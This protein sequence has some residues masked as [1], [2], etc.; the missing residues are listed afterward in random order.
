MD[1]LIGVIVFCIVL[2]IPSLWRAAKAANEA[3]QAAEEA[4][5]QDLIRRHG[6]E[7]AAPILAGKIRQGMTTDQVRESWGSPADI[8]QNILKTKTKETWKY[9]RIG[10]SRY[11]NRVFFEDHIVVGWKDSG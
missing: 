10:K 4:R 8:D 7:I 9:N 6:P 1:I 5:R 3:A 11:S 2:A